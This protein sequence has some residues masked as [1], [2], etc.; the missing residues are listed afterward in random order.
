MKGN[1][2]EERESE[3]E[4][5]KRIFMVVYYKDMLIP[6]EPQVSAEVDNPKP[7][8]SRVDLEDLFYELKD[9]AEDLK[10]DIRK[11]ESLSEL[12]RPGLIVY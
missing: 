7:L 2:A 3:N 11:V 4:R 8:I 1:A 12:F 6:T 10:Q 9:D 5:Q